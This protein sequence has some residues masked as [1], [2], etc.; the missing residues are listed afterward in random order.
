MPIWMLQICFF[1]LYFCVSILFVGSL[2]NLCC[3]WWCH[4]CWILHITLKSKIHEQIFCERVIKNKVTYDMTTALKLNINDDKTL[5][6]QAINCI[7]YWG[8]YYVW[9]LKNTCF[10]SSLALEFAKL[11][12]EQYNAN[13]AKII[14]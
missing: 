14:L 13:Q 9:I 7:R 8:K 3:P 11:M 12:Q 6:I 5:K 10:A 1:R 2:N 4:R